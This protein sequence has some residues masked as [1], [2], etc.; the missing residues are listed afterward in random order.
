MVSMSFSSPSA[1]TNSLYDDWK[2]RRGAGRA[3]NRLGGKC[4]AA[5]RPLRH[6][7]RRADSTDQRN[8]F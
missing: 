3:D 8:T 1:L 2:F 5:P 6:R 4:E 7:F